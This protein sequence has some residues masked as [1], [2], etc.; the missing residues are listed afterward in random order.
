MA[1]IHIWDLNI[2]LYAG[3]IKKSLR[4]IREYSAREEGFMG[5]Y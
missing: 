3:S 2:M 1:G 5:L 4:I